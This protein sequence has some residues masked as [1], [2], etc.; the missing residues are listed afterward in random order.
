MISSFIAE[1]L[2]FERKIFNE[3]STRTQ[4]RLTLE[5]GLVLVSCLL[6]GVSGAYIAYL[7]TYARSFAWLMA[8]VIGAGVFL[9]ALNIQ[10]LFITAGGF[11]LSRPLREK[12][13]DSESGEPYRTDAI[14]VW[15][16]DQ[17]RLFC[18]FLLAVAFSQPLLL[19]LHSGRLNQEVFSGVDAQVEAFAQDQTS[20]V[21]RSRAELV[22]RQR[23]ALDKLT[24][25]GFDIETLGF[26][27][28]PSA[29]AKPAIDTHDT[30]SGFSDTPVS[31]PPSPA[32]V[33]SAPAPD[34][35][36]EAVASRPH[37]ALVIGVQKYLYEKSLFNPTRDAEEMTRTLK[38][39][40]YQVTTLVN[41]KTT[42]AEIRVEIDRYIK[43][44]APGDVS[45]FYF[46][47]H[48]YMHQGNNFLAAADAGGPNA[49]DVNLAQL[50]EDISQRSPRASI[51][52]LDACSSWP[53]GADRNGL[54]HLNRDIKGT[55]VA[56]A[57]SPGQ[58]ALDLPPGQHG[59]FTLYLLK[60][61]R[62]QES[63][64]T[65][66][67]KVRKDVVD[68]VEKRN[69]AQTPYVI[70]VLMDVVSFGGRVSP[71]AVP[72]TTTAAAI[73]NPN[74]R[75]D[76]PLATMGE[77][78]VE[79]APPQ[80]AKDACVVDNGYDVPCLL[81]DLELT[82]ARIAR[83]DAVVAERQP[84]LIRDYRESL[85][86]SG[87]LDDRF[88]LQ[89][90]HPANSILASLV[91]VLLL[92]AGDLVRDLKPLALRHYERERYQQSRRLIRNNYEE[93]SRLT[94]GMLENFE[95]Y[96]VDARERIPVW[97]LDEGFFY[98]KEIRRPDHRDLLSE[99]DPNSV[100]DLI[101][102]LRGEAAAA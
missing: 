7:E 36:S 24:Q 52:L 4:A 2:G 31:S 53:K 30:E 8:I 77:A 38:E 79:E 58:I 57:A 40:G 62:N 91:F 5:S 93:H 85:M 59:L 95:A 83:L 60:N 101:E 90:L 15:R 17:L 39:L 70:D 35:T 44:L 21:E 19:L 45:V 96:R 76:A 66:M 3:L 89:W 26:N 37:K 69:H 72:L 71:T 84:R 18:T 102:E 63:I 6:F 12:I 54:G 86:K 46:S 82:A 51:L 33:L 74:P 88:R 48:G 73:Q 14:A 20:V 75:L 67:V 34:Q 61:L 65:I 28:L 55:L 10:R 41:E 99:F 47:G 100:L 27:T 64:S 1:R 50:I 13:L 98:E 16:P 22:I 97:D 87:H 49:I 80:E 81:A 11:G 78:S 9:F 56:Y 23:A 94:R 43:N 25:S 42:S 32:S 68:Y 29:P 92:W